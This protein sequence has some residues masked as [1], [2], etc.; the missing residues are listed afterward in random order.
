MKSK[1]NLITNILLVLIGIIVLIITYNDE[2]LY[3]KPVMKI[4]KV[5]EKKSYDKQGYG[6]NVESYYEQKIEGIILNTKNKGLVVNT[7]N[8]RSTSNVYDENYHK[9]DKVFV[10]INNLKS[11]TVNIINYKRDFYVVI[12]LLVFI[13]ALYFIGKKQ[14]MLAIVALV[15]N[16]IV[17]SIAINLFTKRKFDLVLLTSISTVIFTIISLSLAIGKNK[18]ALVTI[19]STLL[20]TLV[21]TLIG[22]LV[23]NVTHE[24]GVRIEQ[25]DF[26]LTPYKEVFITELLLGGL[27][28]IMDIAITIASTVNELVEKNNKIDNKTLFL[29]CREIGKDTMGTM[30][31]VLL[32][33]YI[34]CEIPKF[35]LYYRNGFTISTILHSYL[36]IDIVRSLVAGIGIVLAI[37]ITSIISV[38]MLKGGKKQ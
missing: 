7:T 35:I 10:S 1:K 5:E 18:K 17:Y 34:G 25:I 3:K 6:S 26:L 19:I 29:S 12:I 31:N 33:T 4:T 15:A 21:T 36:S 16:V 20:S 2:F 22:V 14:G 8:E 9:G 38:H 28:A 37:P 27:G 13:Y 24:S 23:M 11:K 32:F 30:L